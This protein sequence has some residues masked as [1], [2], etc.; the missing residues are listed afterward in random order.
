[1]GFQ[2]GWVL[3]YYLGYS[4]ETTEKSGYTWLKVNQQIIVAIR[5]LAPADC[6]AFRLLLSVQAMGQEAGGPITPQ[7]CIEAAGLVLVGCIDED[8]MTPGESLVG[9]PHRHLQPLI[10][11]GGLDHI[12]ADP[13]HSWSVDL[14]ELAINRHDP[15]GTG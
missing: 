8:A 6:Y 3:G 1:M 4:A 2:A 9:Q 7:E 14:V 13:G 11:G 15:A 12:E 10:L 5:L